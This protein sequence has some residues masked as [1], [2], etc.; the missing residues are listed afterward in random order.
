MDSEKYTSNKERLIKNLE[1]LCYLESEKPIS[2]MD[3]DLIKVSV[4]FISELLGE[5]VTLTPEEIEEKVRKIPFVETA[6]LNTTQESVKGKTTKVKSHKILLIAAIISILVAIFAI[7]SIAFDWNIFD[8]LKNRFG[9][10][11][12][13]PVNEEIDVGSL[14]VIVN[15]K[16][17]IYSD[18]NDFLDSKDL[19]ALYPETLPDNIKLKHVVF[20]RINSKDRLVLSFDNTNFIYTILFD[21]TVSEDIKNISTEIITINNLEY[22]IIDMPDL[23]LVQVYFTY[24]NNLYTLSYNNKQELI[25]TIENLKELQ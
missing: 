17:I 2:E 19:N 24:N 8:E 25:E 23:G 20:D 11:A 9:T 13:A 18:I 16:P 6:T 14:T 10:V 22:Y 1:I 4:D 3:T 5:E 12:D 7:T 21:E 15:G